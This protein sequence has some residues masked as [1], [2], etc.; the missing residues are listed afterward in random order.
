MF[1]FTVL[2]DENDINLKLFYLG[3]F[4]SKIEVKKLLHF[5]EKKSGENKFAYLAAKKGIYMI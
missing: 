1:Y 4:D 5:D 3:D 2:I